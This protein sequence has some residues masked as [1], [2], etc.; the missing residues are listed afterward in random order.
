MYKSN[1]LFMYDYEWAAKNCNV[2]VSAKCMRIQFENHLHMSKDACA[3]SCL[4][5]FWGHKALRKNVLLSS[6]GV[7]ENLCREK[8][9]Y[10]GMVNILFGITNFQNIASNSVIMHHFATLLSIC[11][12]SSN[13]QNIVS[14]RVRMH[15][16]ESL[17][18]E[19]SQQLKLQEHRCK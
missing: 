14:K 18:L 17:L 9:S 15:H 11:L 16:F 3:E 8:L 10:P 12:S 19:L 7:K 5:V 2:L 1:S 13:F 4:F 6:S